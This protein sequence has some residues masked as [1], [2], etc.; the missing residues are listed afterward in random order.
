MQPQSPLDCIISKA[1]PSMS[2]RVSAWAGL[3]FLAALICFLVNASFLPV[4]ISVQ[5][6]HSDCLEAGSS[7]FTP[8]FD[9]YGTKKATQSHTH[10][11]SVSANAILSACVG[12]I[13]AS[14]LFTADQILAVEALGIVAGAHCFASFACVLAFIGKAAAVKGLEEIRLELNIVIVKIMG[15]IFF[16]TLFVMFNLTYL[17][18]SKFAA[19][20][21]CL[22]N[23]FRKMYFSN[24][25]SC[26]ARYIGGHLDR[27][28]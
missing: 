1:W 2:L 25:L 5:P 8:F 13:S 14:P 17:L 27:N 7:F 16:M 19:V 28:G 10:I 23:A 11:L 15:H 26:C 6:A 4:S 24:T 22:K 12:V 18:L 21:T 20:R 9:I 3:C